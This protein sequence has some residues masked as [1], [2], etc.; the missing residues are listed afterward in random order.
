MNYPNLFSSFSIRN[1]QLKNRL[2]MAPMESHLG[3]AD[4]SVS[5]ELIA[6][7]R[8]RALGGVGMVVVEFTCVDGRDGFSS[9][10]PQLR[11]DTPFFRTGH[12]KLAAAIQS[13]GARACVQLSH[14]GRQ[15]R[16]SVIGRQPV[17]PSAVP[18]KSPY[19]NATPRALEA[20]EMERLIQR[21]AAAAAMAVQAGYDA[22]MLHGAHGYLLQQFLSPLVNQRN[23]EWGGDFERRLRFPLE[24]I[25]AVRDAI[26]DRPLLYRLSVSDFIEGGLTVE[27]S[28]RIAPRLCEAGV[29]A[30]DISCGS[31]DRVDVIVEPMSVPEGWRLPMARRIRKATGKPVICAGVIRRPDAAEAAIAQ[32]DTDIISLGRALLADPLWPKKAQAGKA[33]DIRPCTSCNW[34][35]KETGGNRGV[36]CAENPR[37]GHETDPLIDRF[38]QG[39]RAAVVGAG[40]GGITAALLLDQAGF[41]VTLYEKRAALGGNLVSSAT[42]PGKEKLFWYRDFLLR[43]LAASGVTV[44]TGTAVTA[45][46]LRNDQP[47]VIVLANG[48]RQAPLPLEGSKGLSTGPA[49]EVLLGEGHLPQSSADRPIVIY[50]G[51]ETGTET[52]EHLAKLGQHVLL[53]SRSGAQFLARNAEP[54]Y[55]MHLLKRLHANTAIRILDH[56]RLTAVE[57]D[58]VMLKTGDA[59]PRPQPASAVLLAHGLVPDTAL[60]DALADVPVPV[61][62]IG[63]ARTVARIGEAVR[64]AYRGVQDLRLSFLQAEAI[65]C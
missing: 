53:V 35:I 38:G 62:R 54:L 1:L 14:A 25:R 64:D 52:A 29:D 45:D 44:R 13:A 50:G 65:R 15:S 2:M 49:F 7:Y 18:L 11:L 36:G 22:V 51:G 17:A 19:L 39:H 8:E 46:Q 59:E 16:E 61:I 43:R 47:A 28:E 42:P 5:P 20:H 56:T 37:C 24:V 4:G 41:Q 32:G 33:D 30:I 57:D 34:C 3:N 31:L 63:D 60:A 27:D 40:P 12:G 21:Y 58:H 10:A 23:D 48:S 6:Y 9:L 26:G 55:R